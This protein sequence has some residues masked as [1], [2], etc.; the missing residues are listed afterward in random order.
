MTVEDLSEWNSVMSYFQNLQNNNKEKIEVS[1]FFLSHDYAILSLNND[2]TKIDEIK[3][4]LNE[5]FK[6][7]KITTVSRT[8]LNLIDK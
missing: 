6:G 8:K 7:L 5:K 4:E 1:K 2:M 3:K